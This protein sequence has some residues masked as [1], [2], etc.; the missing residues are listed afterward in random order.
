MLGL[1]G[2]TGIRS[3]QENLFARQVHIVL[4]TSDVLDMLAVVTYL[5]ETRTIS[6]VLGEIAIVLL[7]DIGFT[8]LILPVVVEAI[9]PYQEGQDKG[10]STRHYIAQCGMT[11]MAGHYQS[12]EALQTLLKG[13]L[14]LG[15]YQDVISRYATRYTVLKY[16]KVEICSTNITLIL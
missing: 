10:D 3:K 7:L 12:R 8:L 4:L 11:P 14:K 9:I 13:R 1:S 6:F 15:H 16:T 2:S 5:A